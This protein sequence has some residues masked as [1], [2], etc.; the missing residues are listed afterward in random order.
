[1]SYDFEY[2]SYNHGPRHHALN[3]CVVQV[4]NSTVNE[5]GDLNLPGV[6]DLYR[7]RQDWTTTERSCDRDS[8]V[9]R[10]CRSWYR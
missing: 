6:S 7:S 9:I 8:R 5:P 3:E 10:S 4:T 1:M 2:L